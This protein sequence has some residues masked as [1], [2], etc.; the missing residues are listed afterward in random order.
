MA[1]RRCNEELRA[2]VLE[3]VKAGKP[4]GLLSKEYG[5]SEPTIY[6]WI[7]K[8]K[9]RQRLSVFELKRKVDSQA[10]E[11]TR[12]KGDVE[13]PEEATAWFA[14]NPDRVQTAHRIVRINQ[15]SHPVRRMCRLVGVSTSGYYDALQRQP[16]R[17][18]VH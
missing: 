2:T 13:F 9:P 6:Q 12:L 14:H 18:V 17:L 8:E 16:P 10:R 1:S 15:A 3:Q 11:I 5:I 4:I 7:K